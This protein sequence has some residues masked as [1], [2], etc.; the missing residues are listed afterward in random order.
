MAKKA[1]TRYAAVIF[2]RDGVLADFDYEDAAAFFDS[3]LP[4]TLDDLAVYWHTWGERTGFPG[5]M[6]EEARFWHGFWHYLGAEFAL[7]EHALEQLLQLDYTRFFRPFPDVRPALLAA[8]ERGLR[9]GVLSNFS[10]ASLEPSLEAIGVADLVEVA[11]AATVI[12]AA[13]PAP[14]AY[15]AVTEALGVSPE[16]CLFFDDEA[17]CVAGALALGMDAF[18][19]DRS[20]ATSDLAQGVV[21]DLSV[22]PVLLD[23]S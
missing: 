4:I 23:S 20:R 13:K 11:A 1:D 14:A 8:Q 9:I 10:L 19:V 12:G 2:D 21:A 22:V 15:L 17:P 7:S 18:R 5:S 3:L 6:A 16:S